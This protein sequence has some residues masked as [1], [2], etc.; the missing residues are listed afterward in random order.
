MTQLKTFFERHTKSQRTLSNIVAHYYFLYHL[1]TYLNFKH[2]EKMDFKIQ[3]VFFSIFLFFKN[4]Y[5]NSVQKKHVVLIVADDLG[6]ND[7]SFHGSNQIVTPNIDIL[8][9]SGII[10]QNYYVM[11]VCTP[12]RSALMTGIHPIHTGMQEGVIHNGQPFGLPLNLKILPEYL[13]EYGYKTRAVGKW[14]LGFHEKVYTPTYRGFDSHFGYWGGKDDY[15]TH[16]NGIG[17][18]DGLDLRRNM[19]VTWNYTGQ[20]ST[21]IFTQES[22]DIINS[23]NTSEPL[24]LYLAHQ[25]VH[26]GNHK[27]PLQAPSEIVQKFKYIKNEQ[28]RILA[29]MIWKLDE[30]V[31]KVVQA[32][33]SRNI[34]NDTIII[35]TSDNGGPVVGMEGSHAS[36]W[37]LRGA[38]TT[39]WEGGVRGASFV[40][41]ADLPHSKVSH[42]LMHIQDWLPTIIGA[43]DGNIVNNST[44]LKELDGHNMWPILKGEKNFEYDELIIQRGNNTSALRKNNWKIISMDKLPLHSEWAGP[45]GRGKYYKYNITEI[46]HSPSAIAL[47][48]NNFTI[49][50]EEEIIEVRANVTLS[51]T[52]CGDNGTECT[53]CSQSLHSVTV[54]LFDVS[55]D[56]CEKNNLAYKYPDIVTDLMEE[57]SK[58]VPVSPLNEP[59]DPRCNPMFWKNTWTNWMD[60]E[61]QN[62]SISRKF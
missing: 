59:R 43:I 57:M 13:K 22:V 24:F 35:F 17:I 27:H 5:S 46:Q 23:H 15:Y 62:S 16:K 38:K 58:Y 28:R 37:P 49:P 8:A 7:I 44:L 51:C 25:A 33:A 50:S 2:R 10:L 61:P 6:W 45:S 36:N 39:F 18:Y 26:T 42:T 9:Y 40:W 48:Q 41:S 55:K 3:V 29:A 12:S 47:Y 60:Y 4:S 32:L 11:P 54:C 30:S 52:Y 20:Y 31:G 53:P 21:D 34:L 1:G 19:N 14:H 56:P